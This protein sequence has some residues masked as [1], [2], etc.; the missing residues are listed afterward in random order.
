MLGQRAVNGYYKSDQASE[1]AEYQ[2][3][4]Q[5]TLTVAIVQ[6]SLCQLNLQST[7]INLVVLQI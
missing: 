7:K 3:D 1:C 5:Y 2:V 6:L 4:V